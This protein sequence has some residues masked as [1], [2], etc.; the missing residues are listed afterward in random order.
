M[1]A[2]RACLSQ[3]PLPP[4][5]KAGH[6]DR[7]GAWEPGGT[8]LAAAMAAATLSCGRR[9]GPGGATSRRARAIR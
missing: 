7:T 3:S 4:P 6:L 2:T 9:V 5:S 1:L 8:A